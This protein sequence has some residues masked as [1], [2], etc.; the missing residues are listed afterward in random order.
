MLLPLV[1]LDASVLQP[2]K[3]AAKLKLFT[4]HRAALRAPSRRLMI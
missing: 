4:I 2:E 1:D 3:A